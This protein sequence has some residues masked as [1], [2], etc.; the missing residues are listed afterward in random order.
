MKTALALLVATVAAADHGFPNDNTFHASCHL[1]ATLTGISCADAKAKADTLISTNVDTDS[2]YK[3]T[4]GIHSEGDDW[5][6]STRL[7]YNKKYTDDQLF[8]FTTSGSDCAVT[9]RSKSESMSYLDNGVNYCN[10]WN[11]VSRIDGFT[12]ATASSC[13][14]EASDPVTTCARY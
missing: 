13:K 10:M 11:V 4:M 14:T 5:I 3:G 1:A 12:T 8:E 9:M 6:W 2:E 7:T